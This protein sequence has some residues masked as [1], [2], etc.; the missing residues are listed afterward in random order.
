M[1]KPPKNRDKTCAAYGA[2]EAGWACQC[3]QIIVMHAGGSQGKAGCVC[4]P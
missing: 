3:A 1:S 2:V 4:R